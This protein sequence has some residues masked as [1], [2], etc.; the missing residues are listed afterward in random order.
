MRARNPREVRRR[1]QRA[2]CVFELRAADSSYD[3][4]DI[5]LLLQHT[6]GGLPY[7]GFRKQWDRRLRR[8]R[9]RDEPWP[10]TSWGPGST[11][12]WRDRLPSEGFGAL[13]VVP[14]AAGEPLP[15]PWEDRVTLVAVPFFIPA[16][17]GVNVRNLESFTAGVVNIWIGQL[18]PNATPRLAPPILEMTRG[19]T[20]AKERKIA[21]LPELAWPLRAHPSLRHGSTTS[22]RAPAHHP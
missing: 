10:K 15:E 21:P 2:L 1:L 18:P 22:F 9:G 6:P 14:Y 12:G 13:L 5:Q 19:S 20:R 7:A 17:P 16:N 3:V 11:Q 8:C 4:K